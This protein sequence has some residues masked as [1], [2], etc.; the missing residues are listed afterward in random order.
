MDQR[1]SEQGRTGQADLLC[2][3][4]PAT[5]G[6]ILLGVVGPKGLAYLWPRIEIDQD[7]VQEAERVGR[8]G[9]R[10]RFASTCVQ[11]RCAQWAEDRCGLLEGLA[12]D[13]PEPAVDQPLPHCSIRSDCRW[14]AQR[15]QAACRIC[16]LVVAGP[17]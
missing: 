12:H 6:A 13:S 7:A 16:P 5:E 15:G 4:A 11:A 8:V 1:Q 14:F 2:P 3:S 17:R 9:K 10:L